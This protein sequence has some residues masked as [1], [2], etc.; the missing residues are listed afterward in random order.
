MQVF[1]AIE[2]ITGK[3]GKN[4]RI[5]SDGY[6]T[7]K[8]LDDLGDIIKKFQLLHTR[9]RDGLI[10]NIRYNYQSNPSFEL[11]PILSVEES[12]IQTDKGRGMFQDIYYALVKIIFDEKDIL[13]DIGHKLMKEILSSH[14][15][16]A[17]IDWEKYEVSLHSSA[18]E[19]LSEHH[20]HPFY[21]E[22]EEALKRAIVIYIGKVENYIKDFSDPNWGVED[23]KEPGDKKE[24]ETLASLLDRTVKRVAEK[25]KK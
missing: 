6:S 24:K 21:K 10:E 1:V 22:M 8:G 20:K 18:K 14:K 4:V 25:K 3:Y 23:K 16:I 19:R 9:I 11:N 13:R 2:R 17:S 15:K 5:L 12:I 7:T